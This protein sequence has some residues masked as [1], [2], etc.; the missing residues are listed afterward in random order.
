M[1]SHAVHV[2]V[3]I[4]V[5]SNGSGGSHGKLGPAVTTQSLMRARANPRGQHLRIL[6]S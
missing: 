5:E 2:H 1:S 4:G 3:I 6:H